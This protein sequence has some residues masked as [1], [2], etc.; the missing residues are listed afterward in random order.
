[1][2]ETKDGL[3]LFYVKDDNILPVALTAEQ[4]QAFEILMN[5]IP[6]TIRIVDAPQGKAINLKDQSIKRGDFHA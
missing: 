2:R 1:M 5:A 3:A 4:Q 6:G